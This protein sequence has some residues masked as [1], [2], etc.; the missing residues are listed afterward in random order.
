MNDRLSAGEKEGCCENATVN[1]VLAA[2]IGKAK[3]QDVRVM[4]NAG[5]TQ[6]LPMDSDL[7]Q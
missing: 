3:Q 5:I 2:Y 6:K 4:V 1:A 7:L